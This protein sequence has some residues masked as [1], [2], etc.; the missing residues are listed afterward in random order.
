MEILEKIAVILAS[1]GAINWGL[2]AIKSFSGIDYSLDLVALL[3]GSVPW[4]AATV[5]LL[6]GVS[7]VWML[8][9]AFS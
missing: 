3:L 7:G 4:L 6:V 1:I 2:V 5:Y 9:K 8:V